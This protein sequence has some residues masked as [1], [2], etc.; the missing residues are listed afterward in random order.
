MTDPELV[1]RFGRDLDAVGGPAAGSFAVAVSG[2]ADSLALLLLSAAAFPGRV[3]AATVDHGLRP[4]ARGEAQKVAGLCER[5]GVPHFILCVRVER[6]GEGLQAAAREARYRALAGWMDGE[7]LGLLLTGHH[8]DD[9]AETLLMRLNRGSGVG[10]LAGIRPSGPLPGAGHLRLARPLLGWRREELA[11]I[12]RA[13]GVE[14][15][16]DPS[17]RDPAYDRTRLRADLAGA[18]WL[19]REGVSR[20]AALLAEAEEALAWTA[21]RLAGE[22]IEKTGDAISLRPGDLPAELLRR[23]VLTCLRGIDPEAAPRGEKL[24]GL[25][26]ALHEGRTAT[27]AGVKADA[28]DGSWRFAAAPERRG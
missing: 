20:S 23:L 7:G 14:P 15:A 10:G 13:A 22:R 9:Q 19:D 3:R 8:A 6:D 4:E 5:I 11:G 28:A 21:A 1:S 2:G 25:I 27:L 26:Q 16:V 12:A 17:N 24:S 18:D